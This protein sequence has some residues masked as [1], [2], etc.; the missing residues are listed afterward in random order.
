MKIIGIRPSSFTGEDKS[1]ISGR[2]IYLTYPL[3]KGGGRTSRK[4]ATR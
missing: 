2:N 3:E 1:Q 4:W